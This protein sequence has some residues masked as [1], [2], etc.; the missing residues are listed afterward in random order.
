MP[1]GALCALDLITSG[2]IL[3]SVGAGPA[4]PG[5]HEGE[6]FL[7]LL[8]G[9]SVTLRAGPVMLTVA[10]VAVLSSFVVVEPAVA[11]GAL[12][13]PEASR[14]GAVHELLGA[15]REDWTGLTA[16]ASSEYLI[17]AGAVLLLSVDLVLLLVERYVVTPPPALALE[18][19]RVPLEALLLYATAPLCGWVQA[20]SSLRITLTARLGRV[21][22]QATVLRSVTWIAA[23]VL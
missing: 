21:A 5:G 14:L 6:A 15:V 22:L 17:A 3:E 19:L 7:A 2:A 9:A 16:V 13:V 12:D 10:G 18:L 23:L 20:V 4:L 11:V 1:I 8:A